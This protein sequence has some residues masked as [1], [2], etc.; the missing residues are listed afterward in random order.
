MLVSNNILKS[1][2]CPFKSMAK[3]S[4]IKEKNQIF[5]LSLLNYNFLLGH[6]RDC[7]ILDIIDF[8]SC[9]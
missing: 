5:Y 9:P 4:R 8:L 2:N 3:D 7:T 6:I 1:L